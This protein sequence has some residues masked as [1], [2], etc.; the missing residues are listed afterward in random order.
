MTIGYRT[1][2]QRSGGC[3]PSEGAVST[4]GGIFPV[5]AG[6]AGS[7]SPSGMCVSAVGLSPPRG[8]RAVSLAR[9][10]VVRLQRERLSLQRELNVSTVGAD[11]RTGG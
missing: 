4:V 1:T 10:G 3:L 6:G 7:C 9:K 11:S 8:N 2:P 5:R